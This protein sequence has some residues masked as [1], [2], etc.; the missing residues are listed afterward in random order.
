M[1]A[2]GSAIS[3]RTP[4]FRSTFS[5][6]AGGPS[7]TDG[8]ASPGG[9]GAAATAET[10]GRLASI[11]GKPNQPRDPGSPCSARRPGKQAWGRLALLQLRLSDANALW[12]EPVRS[13]IAHC[14]QLASPGEVGASATAK[15]RGRLA[16][17][18]GKPNRSRGPGSSCC[19]RR[20]GKQTWGRLA[21]LRLRLF[22]VNALQRLV[23]RVQGVRLRSLGRVAGRSGSMR[24]GSAGAGDN[25]T[26][27]VSAGAAASPLA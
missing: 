18:L 22:G 25:T 6:R 11:L 19:A 14:P 5:E 26:C 21:L 4:I 10:R 24:G 13:S 17:I 9:A 8:P 7:P 23:R 3:P 15:T 1:C 12:D 27:G 20:P 2:K 16:S